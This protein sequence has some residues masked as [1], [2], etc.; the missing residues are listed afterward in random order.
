MGFARRLPTTFLAL[1][2]RNAKSCI[3]LSQS[4]LSQRARQNH[5]NGRPFRSSSLFV[6][7]QFRRGPPFVRRLCRPSAADEAEGCFAE[8]GLPG[9][10]RGRLAVAQIPCGRPRCSDAFDLAI[11]GGMARNPR[12]SA[13]VDPM[14]SLLRNEGRKQAHKYIERSCPE[15]SFDFTTVILDAR[16]GG[17][18]ALPGQRGLALPLGFANPPWLPYTWRNGSAPPCWGKMRTRACA[19]HPPWRAPRSAV[20]ADCVAAR[21]AKQS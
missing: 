4:G 16:R 1:T 3:E 8:D 13:V 6:H 20:G 18:A 10:N 9:G 17:W 15:A 12:A 14:S 19:P 21:R 2:P 7:R 5:F 11:T